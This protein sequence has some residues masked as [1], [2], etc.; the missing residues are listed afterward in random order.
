MPKAARPW[1][2][3][4]HTQ[5]HLRCARVPGRAQTAPGD[6]RLGPALGTPQGHHLF[7][8]GAERR[9]RMKLRDF[10]DQVRDLSPDTLLCIA[11]VDEAFAMNVAR[12]EH[13]ETATA[14][15]HKATTTTVQPQPPKPQTTATTAT[16]QSQTTGQ[17]Q[18]QQP[19]TTQP[20]T[21]IT[22]TTGCKPLRC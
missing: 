7:A 13:L 2:P 11:E 9:S 18:S 15:N 10:L 4:T 14:R 6:G 5:T 21:T 12:V 8:S 1:P 16:G 22:A 3:G 20:Q 17:P 19:Q